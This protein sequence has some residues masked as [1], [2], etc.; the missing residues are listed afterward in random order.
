MEKL[1]REKAPLRSIITRTSSEIKSGLDLEEVDTIL[2]WAKFERLTIFNDRLT[3][4]DDRIKEILLAE[5]RSTEAHIA[6]L[7][8]ERDLERQKVVQ[9]K[10]RAEKA[11]SDISNIEQEY[12]N[13]KRETNKLEGQ[14]KTLIEENSKTK[15]SLLQQIEQDKRKIEDLQFRLEE[16]ALIRMEISDSRMA[17]LQEETFQ[18]DEQIAQLESQLEH[19]RKESTTL[20]ERLRSSQCDYNIIQDDLDKETKS[21]DVEKLKEIKLEELENQ[22]KSIE[23]EKINVDSRVADL[24]EENLKKDEQI[25]ELGSQLAQQYKENNPPK[26]HTV[27]HN[28]SAEQNKGKN[29]PVT[30]MAN[31]VLFVGRTN[32]PCL[33]CE[34]DNHLS[35]NCFK[36][37]MLESGRLK[38]VQ[39]AEV[40]FKCLRKNHL[41]R[42][43]RSFVRCRRCQGP[44][45]EIM[46]R[47]ASHRQKNLNWRSD[48]RSHNGS[49]E[50][51]SEKE[52]KIL[53]QEK[54]REKI[55]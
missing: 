53:M 15:E 49:A 1:K 43:C 45:F 2:I 42:N 4:I 44:H 9:V 33:F 26:I 36:A 47:E 37:K 46:C 19:Y 38:K 52:K 18:E 50:V 48:N 23:M 24:Q 17:Q 16:E 7:T 3:L 54:F 41:K 55:C 32:L 28:S 51:I 27:S 39:D 25:S 6:K 30:A 31:Q 12:I 40:C 20:L 10:T 13:L 11:E 34:K 5:S 8:E 21:I 35:Q 22:L 14:V 29:E